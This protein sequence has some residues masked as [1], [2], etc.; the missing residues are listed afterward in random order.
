MINDSMCW[1]YIN[2]KV[3]QENVVTCDE[4]LHLKLLDLVSTIGNVQQWELWNLLCIYNIVVNKY[5]DFNKNIR[6]NTSL[7][8]NHW[9]IKNK[10]TKNMY[11]FEI[12][13]TDKPIKILGIVKLPVLNTGKPIKLLVIWK[14]IINIYRFSV[15]PSL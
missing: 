6:N 3:V 15:V 14:H 12:L 5:L 4:R 10:H 9:F 13:N 11:G 8:W 2:N 7:I 1:K